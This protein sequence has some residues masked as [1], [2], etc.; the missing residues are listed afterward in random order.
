MSVVFVASSKTVS[1]WGASVGISK[2]L[3]KVG[4]ADDARAA[5]AAMNA[6]G[7]AAADDWK[8]VK[9]AEAGELDADDLAARLDAAG[10]VVDPSY[11]PKLRGASGI[12]RVRPET[13]ENALLVEK[14]MANEANLNM[15]IK[16]ADVADWLIRLALR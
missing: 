7:F 9:A 3:Y 1:T 5:I 12:V 6:A 11:Y 16:P 15:K 2:S 13:V 8:L 10:I 14:A 4:L